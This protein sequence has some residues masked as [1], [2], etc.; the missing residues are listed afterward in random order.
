MEYW[1][2]ILS[3]IL[4]GALSILLGGN[5]KWNSGRCLVEYGEGTLSGMVVGDTERNT[6]GNSGWGG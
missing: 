4:R 5:T 1:E 3:R 2:G 6:E